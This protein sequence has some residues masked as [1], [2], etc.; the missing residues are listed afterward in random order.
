MLQSAES[1][2]AYPHQQ[3]C[4]TFHDPQTVYPGSY[5]AFDVRTLRLEDDN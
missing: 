1:G 5:A 4:Q 3:V 2:S